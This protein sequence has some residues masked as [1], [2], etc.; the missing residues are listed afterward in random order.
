[1]HGQH[2]IIVTLIYLLAIPETNVL[3]ANSDT[4]TAMTELVS[5]GGHG[6]S[7]TLE[8]VLALFSVLSVPPD[9]S[10]VVVSILSIHDTTFKT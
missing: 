7:V 3:T 8:S 9:P 2:N 10:S 1:M 5:T 4:T 6:P